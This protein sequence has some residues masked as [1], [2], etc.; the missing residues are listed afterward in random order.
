VI[1]FLLWDRGAGWPAPERVASRVGDLLAEFFAFPLRPAAVTHA[2]CHLVWVELPVE[3]WTAPVHEQEGSD[4]CWAFEYPVN[5]PALA[6]SLGALARRLAGDDGRELARVVPPMCLLHLAPDRGWLLNDGLGAAQLYLHRGP[7][8]WAI[9]NRLALLAALGV[10]LR[11]RAEDWALRLS[12]PYFPDARTGFADVAYVGPGTR[13]RMDA[14]GL[15]LERADALGRWLT[16]P[17]V[18]LDV[19]MG[20]V[21]RSVDEYL[22]LA[23]RRCRVFACGLSGGRD[24]R[25][26]VAAVR[27]SGHPFRLRT[28]GADDSEDVRVARRL[29]EAAGLPLRVK[30]ESEVAPDP[31]DPADLARAV[32]LALRW[33]GGAMIVHKHKTLFARGR[34]FTAGAV[35]VM[36]QYGEVLR[37]RLLR[38]AGGGALDGAG[39]AAA[40]AA[41][42]DGLLA[43]APRFWRPEVAAWVRDETARLARAVPDGIPGLAERLE[44]FYILQDV[45]RW[46]TGALRAQFAATLTPLLTP[47]TL[48]AACHAPAEARLREAFHAAVIARHAPEWVDVPVAKAAGRGDSRYFDNRRLW[49]A[50]GWRG[51]RGLAPDGLDF[52]REICDPDRLEATWLE[53]PDE[54]AL[55]LALPGA[56]DAA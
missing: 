19:A 55:L 53:H 25:A 41:V 40:Y 27:A 54:A 7:R 1:P 44:A 6:D 29:A 2:V 37:G 5:Q 31:G 33:Q 14:A 48:W 36:G 42:V 45:R 3:G 22:G 34:R 35:N 15:T 28:K 11:P 20:A 23:A 12:L 43:R 21:V 47:A 39:P 50:I 26:V 8:G 18:P 38:L 52:A 16:G 10:S 13:C 32:R 17:A 49:A 30:R 56:F 4:R 46:T 51:L 24:S 9:T